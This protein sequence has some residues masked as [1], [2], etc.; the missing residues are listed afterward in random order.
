LAQLLYAASKAL[1]EG[2]T[3]SALVVLGSRSSLP[4]HLLQRVGRVAIAA[5]EGQLANVWPPAG[6]VYDPTRVDPLEGAGITTAEGTYGLIVLPDNVILAEGLTGFPGRLAAL[7]PLLALGGLIMFATE[8]VVAGDAASD[9]LPGGFVARGNVERLL[10]RHT[11]LR[12][13]GGTDWR[14]SEATFDRQAVAGAPSEQE[15]HFVIQ[16]GK[17]FSTTAVWTLRKAGLTPTAA[18]NDFAREWST[19]LG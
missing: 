15:P 14:I 13:V 5:V 17:I 11:G 9:R 12:P 4:A 8:V 1:P 3:A 18:W 2:Q 16:I 10:M 6:V 7:E 19:Q